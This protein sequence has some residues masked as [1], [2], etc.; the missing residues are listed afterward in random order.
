MAFNPPGPERRLMAIGP[1]GDLPAQV[2]RALDPDDFFEPVPAPGRHDWLNVAHEPGQDYQAFTHTATNHT[3]DERR[4]L[5][6][7]PIG[8]FSRPQI[9]L[10]QRLQQ[11]GSLFFTRPMR[12]LPAIG[13]LEGGITERRNRFTDVTQL[14]TRDI[15]ALLARRLPADACCML[16]VTLYDL[17]PD[18]HWSFVFGEA[19]LDDRVGVFSIARYDPRFYDKPADDALLLRRSCKVLAHETCH[20]LGI[21]HCIFFHCLMNG[22]NHM[23]ESDRRPLH[24]CPVD[25]RKLHWSLGF[26]FVQRSSALREFWQASGMPDES[27][28]VERRVRFIA[29]Q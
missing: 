28:W 25:L 3:S 26:D 20:M 17:Y 9:D 4:S 5:Y 14:K 23:E 29:A 16:G 7:Q 11:F 13:V 22:S 1:V 2:R 15:L 12:L 10:L 18:E 6:L 21:R 19:M 27:E 24:L 8:D